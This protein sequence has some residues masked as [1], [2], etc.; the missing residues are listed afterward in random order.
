VKGVERFGFAWEQTVCTAGVALGDWQSF[1]LREANTLA[2]GD[3]DW[4][5]SRDVQQ[6]RE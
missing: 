1:R 4:H 6:G 2:A 3:G 5:V